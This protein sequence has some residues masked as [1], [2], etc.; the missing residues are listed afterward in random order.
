M[1]KLTMSLGRMVSLLR[2]L[3]VYIGLRQ[4]HSL[5]SLLA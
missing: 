3:M 5:A 1:T 4:A 2:V